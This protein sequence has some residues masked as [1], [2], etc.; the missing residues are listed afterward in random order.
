MRSIIILI[1]CCI[2]FYCSIRLVKRSH[3]IKKKTINAFFALIS[4]FFL[5]L[6]NIFPLENY[7]LTFA[8]IKEAYE[9]VHFGKSN[10]EIVVEGNCSDF[11]VDRKKDSDIYLIIPKTENGWKTGLGINTKRIFHKASHGKIV[12][13]YQYKNTNDFFV[14]VL[15]SN[16]GMS[17]ITDSYNSVFCSLEKTNDLLGETFVTYF[18]H[19]T[20]F[21][22]QYFIV[23]NGEKI[24][25]KTNIEE[26]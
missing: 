7:F 2:F 16:G 3:Q 15:D 1:V 24:E 13:V 6:F 5:I 12:Y 23:I 11:V 20:E 25:M 21:N 18:T 26:K 14:T 8:S 4:V 22:E 19:I 9:F 10:I 17:D